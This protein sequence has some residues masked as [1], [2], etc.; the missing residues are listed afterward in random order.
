MTASASPVL[1]PMGPHGGG[2]GPAAAEWSV[3]GAAADGAKHGRTEVDAHIPEPGLLAG[4]E[5][6]DTLVAER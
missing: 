3:R 5:N 1:S 4:H 6:C 2:I